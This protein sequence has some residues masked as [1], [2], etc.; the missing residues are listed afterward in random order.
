MSL[1]E[2]ID[3]RIKYY[4]EFYADR[5][6][7]KSRREIK[8]MPDRCVCCGDIIPEGT[9]VCINCRNKYCEPCR[10]EDTDRCKDCERMKSDKGR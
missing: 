4:R 3:E 1:I 10:H 8:P 6:Q 2:K 5:Y 9:Q 7:A